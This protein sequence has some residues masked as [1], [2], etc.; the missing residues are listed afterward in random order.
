M[1]RCGRRQ[2][3]TPE[4]TAHKGLVNFLSAPPLLHPAACVQPLLSCTPQGAAAPHWARACHNSGEACLPSGGTRVL[5]RA[6]FRG[7]DAA[8]P[9]VFPIRYPHRPSSYSLRS[10]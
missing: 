8:M 3:G 6:R 9:F 2:G 1:A 7:A 4:G 10:D 5:R